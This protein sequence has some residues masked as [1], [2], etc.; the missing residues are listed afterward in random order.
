MPEIVNSFGAFLLAVVGN[1]FT[2]LA[3]CV[4]TVMLALFEKYG[5]KRKLSVKVE[6]A[7]L[8]LFVFFATFQAWRSEYLK[9]RPGLHLK[10]LAI[11]VGALQEGGQGVITIL[12]D[13]SN[14]GAAPTIADNWH[15]RVVSPKG[16]QLFDGMPF[17]LLQ[18]K[19]FSFTFGSAVVSYD[20]SDALYKKTVSPI[21]QGAKVTGFLLFVVPNTLDRQTILKVGTKLAVYCSD[22]YGNEI[23]AEHTITG[24]AVTGW[25]YVPGINVPSM[26]PT[27]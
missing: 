11:D 24:K 10:V 26:E 20:P 8:L 23:H 13:L 9:T 17:A 15:L 5:L 18:G 14:L 27:K 2:L 25:P 12:A 4:A 3:G 1:W 19:P 6:I 7:V 22:V 16:V 21:T